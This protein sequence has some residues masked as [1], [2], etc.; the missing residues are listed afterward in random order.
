MVPTIC[1][2]IPLG[3]SS[4]LNLLQNMVGPVDSYVQSWDLQL[5]CSAVAGIGCILSEK[6][7]R[8][9]ALISL[10]PE[11]VDSSAWFV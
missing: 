4:K 2:V 6:P 8:I 11:L 7:F 9:Y 1:C 10:F 3:L 5:L